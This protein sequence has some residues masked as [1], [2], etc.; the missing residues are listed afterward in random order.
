MKLNQLIKDLPVKAVHGSK[1]VTITGLSTNSK[2]VTPGGLFLARKGLKSD[3]HAYIPEAVAAGA[4]AVVTD[5]YNPTLKVTQVITDFNLEGA[6]AAR[7]YGQPSQK[8]FAVGITGTKGKTSTSYIIRHLLD[9]KKT[10]THRHHRVHHWQ[11]CL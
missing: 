10:G 5:L 6:L 4:A 7:Y 2:R 8:L 1:S 3:G 11:S 9:Q